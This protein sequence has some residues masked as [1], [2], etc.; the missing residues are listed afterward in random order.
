M[1]TNIIHWVLSLALSMIV[2]VAYSQ[3]TATQEVAE[4][5]GAGQQQR[6][7][8]PGL[9]LT[10]EQRRILE[11]LRQGVLNEQNLREDRFVPVVL[12]EEALPEEVINLSVRRMFKVEALVKHKK[13]G[14]T[15]LWMNDRYYDLD[16][17]KTLLERLDFLKIETSDARSGLAGYDNI[18]K[19]RFNIKVGQSINKE[20]A[21]KRNASRGTKRQVVTFPNE[22]RQ[23]K[24]CR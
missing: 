9:F 17:D 16:K 11:A 21:I 6:P 1:K 7:Q 12:R 15:I 10:V 3:E 18:S 5:D 4:Q 8:M 23:K 24:T 19:S 22:R 20:G 13:S 2:G 14:K